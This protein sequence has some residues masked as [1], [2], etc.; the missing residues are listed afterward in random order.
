MQIVLRYQNVVMKNISFYLTESPNL[1]LAGV[2]YST[3]VFH[4]L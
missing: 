4:A 3:E 1:L 2:E